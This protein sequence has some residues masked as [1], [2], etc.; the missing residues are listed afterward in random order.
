[1]TQ[2]NKGIDISDSVKYVSS[3]DLC[4]LRVDPKVNNV[5]DMTKT[6]SFKH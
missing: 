5:Q 6:C 3:K 4:G 2:M 1:M